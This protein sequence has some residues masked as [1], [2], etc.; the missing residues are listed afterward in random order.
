[1]AQP[2]TR[3]DGG[4]DMG[5]PPAGWPSFVGGAHAAPGEAGRDLDQMAGA[6]PPRG[7]LFDDGQLIGQV[8]DAS[9]LS[10]ASVPGLTQALPGPWQ[11]GQQDS[12]FFHMKRPETPILA[13]VDRASMP[14]F[15]D[16]DGEGRSQQ[17][18]RDRE[19][20][21]VST[22]SMD[23]VAAVGGLDQWEAELLE[24]K[25]RYGCADVPPGDGPSDP[26]PAVAAVVATAPVGQF[27]ESSALDIALR[28]EAIREEALEAG[29]GY[30][31]DPVFAEATV[32]ATAPV[33]QFQESSA[34]D[35]ALREEALREEA[36]EAGDGYGPDP[37]IAEAIAGAIAPPGQFQESSALEIALREEALREEALEA[38]LREEAVPKESML[39]TNIDISEMKTLSAS[40]YG[41]SIAGL[42]G[43]Q[44]P[45]QPQATATIL[46]S[47]LRD[48][49]GASLR[50][51][52]DVLDSSQREVQQQTRESITALASAEGQG[53][54]LRQELVAMRG[55]RPGSSG[56]TGGWTVTAQ[57]SLVP[58]PPSGRS[59]EAG[60]PPSS[61][62]RRLEYT[63]QDL[64][65]AADSAKMRVKND[66]SWKSNYSETGLQKRDFFC[67]IRKQREK[68]KGRQ[69]T[70]PL[71]IH[72]ATQAKNLAST[73]DLPEL[74]EALKLFASVRFEDYELYMRLLGE[75][76]HYVTQATAAQLCELVRILARR[77]LRERNYV[78]M[79][80]AHLLQKIRVTDDALPARR[81][82]QAGNSFAALEV[83]SNPKFV[84]HFLRHMEHRM[85]ELDATLCCLVSPVFVDLYANDAIRRAY[86][87]RCAETQAGFQGGLEEARNVACTELV[88][89]KEHHSLLVSLPAHVTRYLDKLKR[90]AQFDKWGAVTLPAS[91]APDG[92]KGNQRAEM[93]FSLQLKS[94]NASCGTQADV[95]SSDMHRDISACLSH[96][97]V[98]H[99][100]GVVAGPYLLDI[101][102]QDM[103]SPAKRIVFEVNSAHHYYEGTQQLTADKRLRH[104]MINRLGHKLHMVNAQ[105]WKKLSAA[106]K[107]TYM[108]KL[109]Q[110]QQDENAKEEKQK[111]AANIARSPLPALPPGK[112]STSDPLRLKS[113]SDLRQPIRIPVPP[114]QKARQ[115]AVSAR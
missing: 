99:E 2:S 89:R 97:G 55:E 44:S 18:N 84:E 114:S 108:L 13:Y 16:P 81:L 57:Q 35:I 77:R 9:I 88:L 69:A 47:A 34:L 87:C 12:P 20:Q 4:Q 39:N 73:L 48:T 98:D 36:L 29:D 103:V 43:Q 19:V 56:G 67:D 111:A 27:Q 45:L 8:A 10:T 37:V 83:R 62:G 64:D 53:Q 75:V 85:N 11:S 15:V 110:A 3:L 5:S 80:A 86:L 42:S 78:D 61:G 21:Q 96:L 76:P 28:E 23:P 46:Q 95:F 79:V 6:I 90:H 66:G 105:E 93:N 59:P 22:R 109:Q 40:Q 30:G 63:A 60:R 107:M 65:L 74:L 71:W 70:G 104:R 24:W 31:S 106:Q 7:G 17:V 51:E 25:R 38:A 32:V 115:A 1:M 49:P 72:L 52:A 58:R 82:V 14:G 68:D 113:I 101:V 94:S 41:S 50:N 100:N 33:G 112:T 91:V 92:P 102:A 54:E 26:A